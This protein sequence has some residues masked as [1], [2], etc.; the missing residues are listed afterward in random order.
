VSQAYY[1]KYRSKS[2]SEIVG[3]PHITTTLSNA[4]KAGNISHAYLLTGPRG[5]GK[6]SVARILAHEI[7][8]FDYTDEDSHIDII[9]IDAASNRRIDEIRDI[10]E[11]VHIAP[12]VGKYKVYIID[13]AHMLT[14][15]AFNALLK[16]LEEPPSHVVFILATTEAHKLPETIISRT[17][18]YSFK[19]IDQTMAEGHLKEIAEKEK[20]K[21]DDDAI[22]LIVKHGMGSFRD[23]IS[24]LDQLASSGLPIVA[25]DV[26]QLLGVP[27]T[28]VAN[29]LFEM[30][31]ANQPL[32]LLKLLA[33]LRTQGITAVSLADELSRIVRNKLVEGEQN[34]EG[35]LLKLLEDLVELP[36]KSR[37]DEY[38]ELAL[39]SLS[40]GQTARSS[41]AP[42]TNETDAEKPKSSET[43]K[44][45]PIKPLAQA[46][47]PEVKPTKSEKFRTPKEAKKSTEESNK[48]LTPE[49]WSDILSSV[50]KDYA[51]IYG[52]MRMCRPVLNGNELTL[53]F[54]F[55]FHNKQIDQSTNRQRVVKI[56]KSHL[57]DEVTLTTVLNPSVELDEPKTVIERPI[58]SSSSITDIFG[59]GE[60]LE[61]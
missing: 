26:R 40:L 34:S 16:T 12:A 20:L 50:K 13:E 32:E 21:I 23:S 10:R 9:E 18:R 31:L 7:N 60:V 8:G 52:I 35:K 39:L 5:V 3:Q 14:K 43:L 47:R 37:P 51:T 49:L 4:I 38:L 28:E 61:S 25:S 44:P 53:E 57:G 30:T 42:L 48:Q 56:I 55:P 27:D 46:D 17:Q 41:K 6:T 36:A 59:G 45:E 15:E 33:D 19:P 29:Q 58:P 24:L 1:R 22:S 11:K 54:K 2:L